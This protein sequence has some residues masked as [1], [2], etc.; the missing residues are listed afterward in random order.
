MHE[1]SVLVFLPYF[2]NEGAH[3]NL[4]L[5]LV[6]L[7]ILHSKRLVRRGIQIHYTIGYVTGSNYSQLIGVYP[8]P[9]EQNLCP[10]YAVTSKPTTKVYR[11]Y[12]LN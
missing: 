12:L 5:L 4:Q 9:G 11:A 6:H 10:F 2:L 7:N 1:V 3:Y 8:C